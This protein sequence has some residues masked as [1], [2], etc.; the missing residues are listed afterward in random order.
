[1]IQ[2]RVGGVDGQIGWVDDQ[3]CQM[4]TGGD[5]A[6]CDDLYK[7]VAIT[8]QLLDRNFNID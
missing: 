2:I 4:I 8:D 1:M 7:N 6:G 3:S 5:G